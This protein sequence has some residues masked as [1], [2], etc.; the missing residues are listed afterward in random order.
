M[1]EGRKGRQG[2]EFC[3]AMIYDVLHSAEFEAEVG[4]LWAEFG[5]KGVEL[6]G[7][8][9]RLSNECEVCGKMFKNRHWKNY[10]M[11]LKHTNRFKVCNRLSLVHLERKMLEAW[12]LWSE[13]ERLT[14]V[15]LDHFYG[16]EESEADMEELKRRSKLCKKVVKLWMI[17]RVGLAR[18]LFRTI[19]IIACSIVILFI[20]AYR[21]VKI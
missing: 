16:E 6:E 12:S 2:D 14:P 19:G 18:S 8:A 17:L 4:R 21:T 20:M 3:E 1:A 5:R 13:A 7:V 15:C 10:H 11:A 9:L